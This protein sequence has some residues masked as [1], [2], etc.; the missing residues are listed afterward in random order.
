[1]GNSRLDGYHSCESF[2]R[3]PFIFIIHSS[4]LWVSRMY[5]GCWFW[6]PVILTTSWSEVDSYL[7]FL[8][9][10]KSPNVFGHLNFLL[11]IVFHVFSWTDLERTYGLFWSVNILIIYFCLLKW[12]P[13]GK[14]SRN[15]Q[16]VHSQ[17]YPSYSKW[18]A[19]PYEMCVLSLKSDSLS[20]SSNY[21][22]KSCLTTAWAAFGLEDK[23]ENKHL[24]PHD[25]ATISQFNTL[26]KCVVST[27][28]GGKELKTQQK[29][30]DHREVDQHCSRNCLLKNILWA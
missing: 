7:D 15:G 10:Q 30:Q 6:S 9:R 19:L 14:S 21:L 5:H 23:K 3:W 27:I 22:R 8:P 17:K 24:A 12:T 1:M 16:F 2:S 18:H 20:C 11:V 13:W 4:W 26:T 28:L 25:R 29:S